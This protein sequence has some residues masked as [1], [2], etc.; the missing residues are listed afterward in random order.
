M[1]DN[2]KYLIDSA[3]SENDEL[4]MKIATALL[5]QINHML[6]DKGNLTLSAISSLASSAL[7]ARKLSE[8]IIPKSTSSFEN[9]ETFQEVMEMLDKV[10][11]F[12]RDT[13]GFEL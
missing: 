3:I 11:A 6:K 4:A 13:P 10:E 2:K 12:K 7:K 9:T 1:K 8:N 5:N